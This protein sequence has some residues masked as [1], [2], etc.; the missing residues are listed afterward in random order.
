MNQGV[1]SNS[2]VYVE[3][4]DLLRKHAS[5]LW[6]SSK[7]KVSGNVFN[8]FFLRGKCTFECGYLLS[9]TLDY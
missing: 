3:I 6:H 4:P 7:V 8:A 9:T 1:G 5:F 2:E